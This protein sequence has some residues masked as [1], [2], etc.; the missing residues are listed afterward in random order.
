[1]VSHPHII[2]LAAVYESKT[3]VHIVTE[4]CTGGTILDKIAGKPRYLY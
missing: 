3:H 4:L 1:M 2:K